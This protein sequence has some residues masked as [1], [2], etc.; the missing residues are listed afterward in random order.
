MN[1][2]FKKP[3]AQIL[4]AIA[5]FANIFIAL[6]HVAMLFI[7]ASAYESFGAPAS[8]VQHP[9]SLVTIMQMLVLIAFFLLVGLY[10]LSGAELLRRFPLT[11]TVLVVIGVI[12]TLRGSMV[13]LMPFPNLI[14]KKMVSYP[15][16][17]GHTRPLMSQDWV[18]S[19]IALLIGLC[20][21]AGVKH[22][23]NG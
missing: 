19:F 13:F 18:F 14:N 15:S 9:A 3:F 2:Q 1:T 20:Y 23:Y 12:Y 16:L 7:G 17:L 5:G 4:L 10:A 6:L 11:K 8:F 22:V 21:L